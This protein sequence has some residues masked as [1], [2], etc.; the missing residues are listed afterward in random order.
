MSAACGVMLQI[1]LRCSH[2]DPIMTY[3]TSFRK[4][5]GRCY[6]HIRLSICGA[7]TVVQQRRKS[8]AHSRGNHVLVLRVPSPHVSQRGAVTR[9]RRSIRPACE[10]WNHLETD[11]VI[12]TFCVCRFSPAG[13]TGGIWDPANLRTVDPTHE[14]AVKPPTVELEQGLPCSCQ[15][16]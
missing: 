13:H 7:Q 12:C 6:R 8:V 1:S 11:P 15:Y 16:V 5:V 4:P 2:A 9:F 10:E 3:L 14:P